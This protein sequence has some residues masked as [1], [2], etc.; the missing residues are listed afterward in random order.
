MPRKTQKAKLILSNK[1]KE[2]LQKTVQSRK[3]PHARSPTG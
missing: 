1:Q 2:E 3:A